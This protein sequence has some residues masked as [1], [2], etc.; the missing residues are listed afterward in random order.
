MTD[1]FKTKSKKD[2]L[3]DFILSRNWTKSHEVVEWGIKNYHIRADRD[4]QDLAVEGSIRRM[5]EE[6]K[7]SNGI[8]SREGVWVR[9]GFK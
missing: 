7:E 1:L 3:K 2:M 6:E 5:T 4:S 9:M 8:F